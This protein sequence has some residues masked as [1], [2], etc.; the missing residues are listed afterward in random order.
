MSK[1]IEIGALTNT[2]QLQLQCLTVHQTVGVFN[3][4]CVQSSEY[5][6][7]SKLCSII[8]VLSS[9]YRA[10]RAG[11]DRNAARTTMRLLDSIIRLSQGFFY[12]FLAFTRNLRC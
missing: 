3:Q 8:R 6:F 9:Y 7:Q 12:I 1:S 10:Q 5:C 2:L 11:D 4:S